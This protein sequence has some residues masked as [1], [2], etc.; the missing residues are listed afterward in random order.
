MKRNNHGRIQGRAGQELRKRR[1][2]MEPLCRRC[3]EEGRTKLAD[4]ID[5]I[6]PLGLGGEDVDENCQALCDECHAIKTSYE[7]ASQQGA[8]FHPD[9]LKPSAI[10]LTIVCGPPCSGKTT[11]VEGIAGEDDTVICLDTIMMRLKPGYLHWMQAQ[12]EDSLLY[13][14][15]RVRNELL[16]SLARRKHGRAWFIVSAPSQAERDWWQGKL[17]GEVI[18][19]HPGVAECKRRAIARGTPLA[20]QGIDRWERNAKRPWEPK[21][22]K[23]TFGLDGWP[24]DATQ[25]D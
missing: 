17:G 21:K 15:V 5:H 20:Q 24:I 18:L 19:L 2:A 6:V 1:L 9:W 4:V 23:P 7:A 25:Q 16:G 14:A 13:R 8:A 12:L 3:S 11:M 22:P 10:P